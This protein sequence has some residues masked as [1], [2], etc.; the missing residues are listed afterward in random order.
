MPT[1]HTLRMPHSEQLWSVC[2]LDLRKPYDLDQAPW[3]T[4]FDGLR[5]NFSECAG[6]WEKAPEYACQLRLNQWVKQSVR[7]MPMHKWDGSI[8]V[9]QGIYRNT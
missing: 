1:F 2:F 7:W 6:D 8:T 3:G 9:Q 4:G 5:G